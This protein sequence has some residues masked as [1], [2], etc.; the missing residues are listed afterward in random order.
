[1]MPAVALEL[2]RLSAN[3]DVPF[4]KVR[5]LIQSEPLLAAKVLHTAQSALYSRGAAIT[6]LDDAMAR[7]GLRTLTELF[8]QAAMTT[9]VFRADGYERPMEELRKHSVVAG[10]VARLVC[11][12]TGDADDYAFM[13]GL[14]HDVGAAASILILVESGGAQ[15][16]A[17][18][19]VVAG[20]VAVHQEAS[21]V[22]G[23][24]WQLPEDVQSVLEHHHDFEASKSP[25]LAASICVSDWITSG[26]GLTAG[27]EVRAEDA[28][29]AIAY[30]GLKSAEVEALVLAGEN[31]VSGA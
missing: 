8:L 2:I 6:S 23:K 13:C 1:M 28:E 14:L 26:L 22:L 19:S 10:N 16:P 24:I 21:A 15:Q 20:V 27:D 17:F 30:L 29:R 18:E 3:P 7:L 9:R 31:F 12:R 5:A 4:H 25:R 11:R